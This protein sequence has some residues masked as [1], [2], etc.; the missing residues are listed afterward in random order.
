MIWTEGIKQMIISKT[1]FRISFFGG[2]TDL[3][4]YFEDH[5]GAVLSTTFDKYCYVCIRHLP[6]FFEYRNQV[7]YSKIE[8]T[9]AVEDLEHPMVRNAML[10]LDMHDLCISY[11]ADLPAR[12]GLGSSSSFAVGLLN[13][14]HALKGQY[15][16]KRQLAEEAIYVERVLCAESGGWQDQIAAS[17]GGMNRITFNGD[18]FQ[19]NPVIVSKERKQL[20]NRNL[21][22]FF[23]GFSRFSHELEKEK[24]KAIP[25]KTVE[26]REMAQM[27]E[28]GERILTDRHGDLDSF[29]RLLHDAW[30]LK[31]GIGRGVSS[32]SLD[33][34]YQTAIDH[35][36][37]GGKLL[38]AGGGGF[39]IFYTPLERQ[40]AV[41]KALKDF[42]FIPFQFEEAGTRILYYGPEDYSLGKEQGGDE[43]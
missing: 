26:L 23:T 4:E 39:F 10:Y 3:R 9:M 30:Q 41:K 1:P 19:V 5:G 14:C 17:Y 31:R 8:K 22:M 6:R 40:E 37:I 36:A 13:A 43:S 34:I 28:E 35:G 2:G 18:K 20:L 27:A 33:V 25:N 21:L 16:G 15:A 12:S 29:G 42:L 38:G 32:D 24:V 11:D 7:T